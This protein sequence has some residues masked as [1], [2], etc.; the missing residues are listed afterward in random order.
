MNSY[1]VSDMMTFLQV[2]I[3]WFI[4]SVPLGMLIGSYLKRRAI[5]EFNNSH[6]EP[7]F[8]I[9][10]GGAP[11]ISRFTWNALTGEGIGWDTPYTYV[12]IPYDA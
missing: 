2:L 9:K 3:I 12:V 4:L 10:R 5:A 6:Y 7:A 1:T 11:T 8:F